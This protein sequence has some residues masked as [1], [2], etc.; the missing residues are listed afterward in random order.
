[1]RGTLRIRQH[2]QHGRIS[3]YRIVF[4]AFIVCHTVV[5][6]SGSSLALD[7]TGAKPG[8]G[9]YNRSVGNSS[10]VTF[11]RPSPGLGVRDVT[12]KVEIAR[13]RRE[14]SRGLMFRESLSEDQGMLFVFDNEQPLGFWMKNT[15][16]AL[17]IIF[18]SEDL[19]IVSAQT[20]APPCEEDPCPVYR[21][22]KPAKFV[23]EVNA[24]FVEKHGI[25]QGNRVEIKIGA[26]RASV[27]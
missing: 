8:S 5:L 12:V 1:M 22:A 19:E 27:P 15:L 11:K 17:D 20:R 13:T 7:H 14:I 18:I 21:S 16:I 23:V 2:K 6:C 9:E 4:L 26:V 3:I 24:G 25:S 10:Y